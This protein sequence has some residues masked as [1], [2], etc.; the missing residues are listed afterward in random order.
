MTMKTRR[1]KGGTCNLE[2]RPVETDNGRTFY[3][4]AA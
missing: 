2:A 3:I 4:S 1:R